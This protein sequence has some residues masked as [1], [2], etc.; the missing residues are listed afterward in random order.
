[1]A[2]K[3]NGGQDLQTGDIAAGQ[4]V[5]VV[6]DGAAFQLQGSSGLSLPLTTKGDLLVHDG[7]G[8]ARLP[9]DPTNGKVLVTDSAQSAGVKWGTAGTSA[10]ARPIFAETR[11]SNLTINTTTW[12]TVLSKT[13]VLTTKGGT[14][15]FTVAV[16]F[17]ATAG[18][19]TNTGFFRLDVGST[20]VPGTAVF[21]IV[22]PANLND[23]K[24]VTHTFVVPSS[25]PPI[26]PAI[27]SIGAGTYTVALKAS[28]ASGHTFTITTNCYMSVTCLE[29]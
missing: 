9:V 10:I 22:S 17:D 21:K 3:K 28:A 8:L 1:M 16:T 11:G 15:L 29:L 14:L 13:N 23:I 6:Y 26:S 20:S 27:P 18:A 5:S 2:L 4:V 24:T 19:G 25:N 7:S 12:T